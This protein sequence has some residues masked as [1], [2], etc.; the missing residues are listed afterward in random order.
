MGVVSPEF[1]RLVADLRVRPFNPHLSVEDARAEWE[2]F[3]SQLADPPAVD[4]EPA[5]A[6]GVTVEWSYPQG[7][8]PSGAVLYLHGGGY[9]VGSI[10]SYRDLTARITVGTG[11]AVCIVEYR[12]A[13]EHPFPAAVDDAIAAYTGLLDQIGAGRIVVAGDSAGGGLSAAL[14]LAARHLGLPT[15][16]GLA[17]VSPLADLSQ[18][19]ASV[20]RNIDL[21][22][23]VTPHGS[24][25]NA[26]RYLGSHTDSGN[27]L[28]SP[29]YADPVDLACF[30][31]TYIQVGTSEILLDDSLRLARRLRDAGAVVDLDVWPD[32]IHILPFFASRVPEARAALAAWNDAIGRLLSLPADPAASPSRPVEHPSERPPVSSGVRTLAANLSW[33]SRHSESSHHSVEPVPPRFVVGVSKIERCNSQPR[34]GER[35]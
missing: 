22:P 30:P 8:N 29:I 23:L 11:A 10:A 6:N 1:E 35:P 20:R 21:D 18:T 24:H 31:L 9:N 27:P 4:R 2:T 33:A 28:A 15:P 3:A 16:A 25:A 5:V 34:S 14:T 32:M 7:R 19:G 17:I 26:R 12:L 13:P